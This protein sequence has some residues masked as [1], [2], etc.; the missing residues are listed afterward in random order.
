MTTWMRRNLATQGYCLSD[1]QKRDL[2]VALRVSTRLCLALVVTA[3]AL[4]SGAMLLALV[5]IGAFAGF[6][7]RHLFD[8]VWNV[9]LR[10]VVGAWTL[11]QNVATARFKLA[12]VMLGTD[13]IL[14]LAGATT[15]PRR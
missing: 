5:P 15:A 11:P 13:T 4:Q 10:R 8:R 2:A 9:A 1:V 7:A 6:T 12:T 14:F 3:L